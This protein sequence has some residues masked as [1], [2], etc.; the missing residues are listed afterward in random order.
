MLAVTFSTVSALWQSIVVSAGCLGVRHIAQEYAEVEVAGQQ[1]GA[2]AL[3]AGSQ[4]K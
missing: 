4:Q 1:A 3:L 2:A